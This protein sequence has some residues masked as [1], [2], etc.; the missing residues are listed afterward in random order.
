MRFRYILCEGYFQ[1]LL[2]KVES[3][4]H[5]SEKGNFLIV[6]D[7]WI[8]RISLIVLSMCWMKNCYLSFR[9][10]RWSR[11]IQLTNLLLLFQRCCG[12]TRPSLRSSQKTDLL[13]GTI[14]SS[15]NNNSNNISSNNNNNSNNS[16]FVKVAI[17]IFERGVSF[18]STA[19]RRMQCI[20]HSGDI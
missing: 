8:K 11:S 7:P 14:G 5:D 17:R 20:D 12:L 15:S 2:D 1:V 13:E 16:N 4:Q 9:D 10:V 3:T 18:A 19:A 6:S